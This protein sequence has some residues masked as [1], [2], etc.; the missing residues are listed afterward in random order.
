MGN[1]SR[2]TR[3]KSRDLI[4]ATVAESP[5]PTPRQRLRL[6]QSRKKKRG[7]HVCASNDDEVTDVFE[8]L[9]QRIR[10]GPISKLFGMEIDRDENNKSMYVTQR[11]YI[12]RM[13]IKYGMDKSKSVDTPA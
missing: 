1:P 7:N 4:H 8:H 6:R 3:P 13:A 9:Q 11:T 10:L 2:T 5:Q 12:K